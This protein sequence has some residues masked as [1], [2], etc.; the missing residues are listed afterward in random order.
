MHSGG[1]SVVTI[2]A[3]DGVHIGHRSVIDRVRSLA[4]S[5]G[6][7]SVVVTFDRHP[8]SVVRPESAPMLLTD[9]PQ[10]LE[11][12]EAT[13]VDRVFVVHFD[14]ERAAETADDFVEVVLV[15]EL[16]AAAVVVG[17]DF[18]FGKDR[19]GNLALLEAMGEEYDFRVEPFDLVTDPSA[20]EVVSSTRIRQCIA[21][22]DLAEA[23]RLLGRP[24]QVRGTVEPVATGEAGAL[25][26]LVPDGIL[27][28]PLGE[29][30]VRVAA[31][32]A[33]AETPRMAAQVT[34]SPR[35]GHLALSRGDVPGRAPAE[36][37]QAGSIVRVLFTGD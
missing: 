9:L 32:D 13:G 33:R 4:G 15:R 37:F 2:G 19:G 11:L 24:H 22:G 12:L 17:R 28:P 14:A 10:K 30:A 23:E 7:E 36:R 1:R 3:Y 5:E 20:Q 18:H 21:E 25:H 31:G 6:L 29:Y 8:A 27:L 34:A 35:G 16:S 26:L